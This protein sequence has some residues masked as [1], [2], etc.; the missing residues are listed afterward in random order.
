MNGETCSKK[1]FAI[2]GESGSGKSTLAKT[3]CEIHGDL[4]LLVTTTSRPIRDNEVN[5]VDYNFL[6]LEEFQNGID[7]NKFITHKSFRGWFYG[8]DKNSIK[9]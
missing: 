7:N 2:V 9:I 3:L 5:G 8:L 4:E 6:T 1:I